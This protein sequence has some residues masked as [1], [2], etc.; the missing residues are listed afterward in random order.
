MKFFIDENMPPQLAE[1]LAILEKP[2][3]EGNE[4]FSIQKEYGRGVQDEE[5]IPRVGD[6]NGI[7][8]TQDYNLQRTQQQFDLLRKYKMGIFY[9]RPPGKT[10]Y[11]YWEMVK[12]I[13][14][15]WIEIKGLT[16]RT[17]FPFAYRIMPRGKIEKLG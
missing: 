1:G 12:K 14:D 16:K 8:I 3:D 11:K 9:L 2:N 17:R 4:I 13:I 7:V 6:L 10:G 15:H 5:W